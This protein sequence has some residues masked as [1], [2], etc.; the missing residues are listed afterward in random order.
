[1]TLFGLG[2]N[3]ATQVYFG[4]AAATIVGNDL[5]GFTLTVIAPAGTAGT[6][7][8]VTVTM[9]SGTSNPVF[10]TYTGTLV[11]P[12]PTV[13][14]LVPTSGPTSGATPFVI[15]GANLTGGTVTFGGVP[16][17]I[18]ASAPN[19]IVGTVPPGAV[20]NVA[21]VVTTAGGAATV[22]GGYTY[23][24]PP[25]PPPTVTVTVTPTTSIAA[26]G[27]AFTV[28]GTNLAGATV[29][30]GGVGA[31]VTSNTDTTI[32]GTV[33]AGTV[34]TIVPVLVTTSGGTAFAGTLTYV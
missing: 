24:S 1:V 13:T 29:T 8:P 6:T 17:T 28:S 7:V 16:A 23:V 3:G 26:G 10:Y 33:P 22:L 25:P 9:P 30:F 11:P 2:L 4:A 21:V 20:G 5:L 14:T 19:L 31:T 12:P 18:L 15:T 27:G 34:G 32:T